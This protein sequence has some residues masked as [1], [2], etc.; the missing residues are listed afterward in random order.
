ML[1]TIPY[2]K[3]TNKR[4]NLKQIVLQEKYDELMK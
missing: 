1:S 2:I 4:Y 3:K